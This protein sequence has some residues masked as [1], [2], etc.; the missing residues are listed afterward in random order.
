[1]GEGVKGRVHGFLGR[2]CKW[3]KVLRGGCMDF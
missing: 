2:G 3:E 1:M